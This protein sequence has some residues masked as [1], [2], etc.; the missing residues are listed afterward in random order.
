MSAIV[1]DNLWKRCSWNH[2]KK[3]DK[4]LSVKFL[5]SWLQIL[6]QGQQFNKREKF[7]NVNPTA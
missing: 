3:S 2:E 6:A 4:S 7:D 1:R 5:K